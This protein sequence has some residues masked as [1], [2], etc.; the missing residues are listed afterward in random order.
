MEA[1]HDEVLGAAAELISMSPALLNR[2]PYTAA[3][4]VKESLLSPPISG[5][6]R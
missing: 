4:V 6:A 1:E 2:L 3:V 5:I